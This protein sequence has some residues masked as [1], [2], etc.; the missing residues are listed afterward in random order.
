VFHVCKIRLASMGLLTQPDPIGIAGGFG[1]Y[2][3]AGGDP[4]NFGDPYGLM[5]ANECI[6]GST[7]STAMEAG[8]KR[9]AKKDVR[10]PNVVTAGTM[11]RRTMLAAAVGGARHASGPHLPLLRSG[12]LRIEPALRLGN[13][14]RK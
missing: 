2:A 6:G 5:Q 1:L 12:A 4:V 3:Y 13:G 8:P 14:G 11:H 7:A 10:R 9:Q